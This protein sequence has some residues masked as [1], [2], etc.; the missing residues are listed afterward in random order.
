M[1]L[2]A[3][4]KHQPRH[5]DTSMSNAN[6]DKVVEPVRRR[7]ANDSMAKSP[8]LF[9]QRDDFSLRVSALTSLMSMAL[10][11]SSRAQRDFDQAFSLFK[12]SLGIMLH[13]TENLRQLAL[14][15]RVQT[16]FNSA[17]KP[18]PNFYLIKSYLAHVFKRIETPLPVRLQHEFK[19]LK[20]LY[21]AP[22]FSNSATNKVQFLNR[23]MN[24]IQDNPGTSYGT[25]LSTIL[26]DSHFNKLKQLNGHGFWLHNYFSGDPLRKFMRDL[27]ELDFG[28][29]AYHNQN[30]KSMGR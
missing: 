1:P 23:L 12:H 19:R 3:E 15:S 17:H 25:C 22:V 24:E 28:V 18:C 8:G 13:G 16:G 27:A 2:T 11:H 30:S 26:N 14:V 5:S 29:G 7:S 21:S 20:L 9:S 10:Y 4:K 6:H